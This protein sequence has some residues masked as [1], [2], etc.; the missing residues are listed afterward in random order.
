MEMVADTAAEHMEPL[1]QYW[2]TIFEFD[3]F[4][5]ENCT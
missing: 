1:E 2:G 4:H 5:E 3:E